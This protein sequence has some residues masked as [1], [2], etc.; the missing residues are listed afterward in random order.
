MNSFKTKGTKNTFLSEWRIGNH[1]RLPTNPFKMFKH[2][3]LKHPLVDYGQGL[4][5][6]TK[7]G[8]GNFAQTP[9]YGEHT[10]RR[11]FRR[12]LLPNKSGTKDQQPTEL[13]GKTHANRKFRGGQAPSSFASASPG[14]DYANARRCCPQSRCTW[15]P[16]Y[17]VR[18]RKKAGSETG[19]LL[20]TMICI[21]MFERFNSPS[22]VW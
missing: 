7:S 16:G 14:T 6:Q 22:R 9:Q 15:G 11:P 8:S 1:R 17:W 18:L 3:R 10:N 13:L 21:D 2:M 19:F 5:V 4:I 12:F 20:G